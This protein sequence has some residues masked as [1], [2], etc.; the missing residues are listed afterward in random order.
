MAPANETSTKP[1]PP[2]IDSADL[3]SL[4]QVHLKRVGCDPGA[5]NGTWTDKSTHAMAQFNAHAHTNF[6]V[7][8]A[9]LGA[10]E[11]VR[12]HKDRVCPLDC[13]KGQKA[14]GDRC[15]AQAC[16][17]GYVHN[18]E[19]ECVREAKTAERPTKRDQSDDSNVICDRNGCRNMPKNCRQVYYNSPGSQQTICN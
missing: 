11:A 2:A 3:A 4:L 1:E 7:K 9:S 15:V 5:L 18:K 12:A 6:D 16:K 17:P 19:G 8:V 10:L 13:G 14:E